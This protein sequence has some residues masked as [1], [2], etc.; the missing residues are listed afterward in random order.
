MRAKLT[1]SVTNSA[2]RRG[3]LVA[4]VRHTSLSD[5]VSAFLD[6]LEIPSSNPDELDPR[7]AAMYG[8]YKLPRNLDTDALRFDSLVRKHL[9]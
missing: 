8:A 4:A 5:L 3:K 2:I 6:S 1:L 9:K 7:V